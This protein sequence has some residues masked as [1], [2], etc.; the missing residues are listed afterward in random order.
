[1]RETRRGADGRLEVMDDTQY[2]YRRWRLCFLENV[3]IYAVII[4]CT[5]IV[6]Y[7]EKSGAGLISMFLALKLNSLKDIVS[8]DDGDDDDPE[9]EDDEEDGEPEKSEKVGLRVVA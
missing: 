3:A 1:M 8:S 7:F 5:A 4:M 9:E 6:A 2:V